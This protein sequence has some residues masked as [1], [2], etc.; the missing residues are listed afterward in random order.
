VLSAIARA[1]LC[2]VAPSETCPNDCRPGGFC[3]AGACLCSIDCS[4][5][6]TECQAGTC[7]A[8]AAGANCVL[9]APDNSSCQDPRIQCQDRYCLDKQGCIGVANDNK[10]CTD[11][12]A[13][14]VDACSNGTCISVKNN[15]VSQ[16]DD[17]NACTKN[18]ACLNN[19]TCLCTGDD[20]LTCTDDNLC[21]KDT[22]FQAI[23]R[24][25]PNVQ[26]NDPDTSDCIVYQCNPQTGA[27]DPTP[28]DPGF[29]CAPPPQGDNCTVYI[30][31]RFNANDYRTCIQNGRT[32]CNKGRCRSATKDIDDCKSSSINTAGI[33]GGVIAGVAF[34][35]IL[36]ICLAL[37]LLFL[38]RK[39]IPGLQGLFNPFGA[40]VKVHDAKTYNDP[41]T[42]M[43]SAL[44]EG[45]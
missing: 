35:A 13:C 12:N 16:C 10:T 44:H 32:D 14:T 37:L 33:I 38:C 25:V 20:S 11:N 7:F 15:N 2:D 39:K 43:T 28:V 17:H 19:G 34:L 27:C 24:S 45:S 4:L 6:S 23:C 21:T 18:D 8:N 31:D 5:Q 36:A 30:C 9:G 40:D 3:C 1:I 26:C 22:C 41:V 29:Q 42:T